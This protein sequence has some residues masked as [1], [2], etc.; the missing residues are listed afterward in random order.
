MR[1]IRIEFDAETGRRI[2]LPA[3]TDSV[4]SLVCLTVACDESLLISAD[5]ARTH[6]AVGANAIPTSAQYRSDRNATMRLSWI[7]ALSSISPTP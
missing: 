1:E 4:I 6:A 7:S 5:D 2:V 3:R